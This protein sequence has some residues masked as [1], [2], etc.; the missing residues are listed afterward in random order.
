MNNKVMAKKIKG[1]RYAVERAIDLSKSGKGTWLDK[2][3]RESG[4]DRII[5]ECE[6]TD[7]ESVGSD[8]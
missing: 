8:D 1:T 6:E 4:L 5:P 7:K 2:I 3:R